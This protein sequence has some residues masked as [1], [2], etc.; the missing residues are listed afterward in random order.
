M[1][2]EGDYPAGFPSWLRVEV[3]FI[4]E[5]DDGRALP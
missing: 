1:I 2:L 5:A 3:P 4:E